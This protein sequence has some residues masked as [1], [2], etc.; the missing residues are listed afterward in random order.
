MRHLKWTVWAGIF[1]LIV[2]LS[3]GVLLMQKFSWGAIV[4]GAKPEE[5]KELMTALQQTLQQ[6]KRD[7]TV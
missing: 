5:V 6:L 3:P 4:N 1:G 7:E 2:F